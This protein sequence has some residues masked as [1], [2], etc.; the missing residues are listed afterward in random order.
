[1]ISSIG[2]IRHIPEIQQTE[3]ATPSGKAGEFAEALREAVDS[4]EQSLDHSAA[5]TERLLSGQSE[6]L[7]SVA[8][9]SQRAGLELELFL[10]VRNKVVQAYQEVMRTQ[11]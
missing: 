9:A 5:K 10:E 3:K 11:V 2:P 7:H 1:M 6:D 8:L 4:V